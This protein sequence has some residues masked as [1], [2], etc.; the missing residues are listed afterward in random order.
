MK[1]N[2]HILAARMQAQHPHWTWSK[3]CAELAKGRRK[4]KLE[5]PTV[6]QHAARMEQL[7]LF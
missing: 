4:P 2:W 5:R 7:R 1:L 3:V 6:Q